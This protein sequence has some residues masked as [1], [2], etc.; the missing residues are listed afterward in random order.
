MTGF[1]DLYPQATLRWIADVN[2]FMVYTTGGMPIGAYD[3]MRMS[4]L[5]IGHGA[6]DGGIGYT[7]FDQQTGHEFSVAAGLTYNLR[8]NSTQYQ[9]GVDFHLDWAA[10]QFLS[11]H[12]QLGVAGYFYDQLTADT[13]VPP[14]LGNFET[15]V[16]GLGP[17]AGYCFP[18][19]KIQGYLNLKTYW[20]FAA[21]NRPSGWNTFLTFSITA[22]GPSVGPSSPLI[23]M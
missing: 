14:G 20:E 19:Q 17:Q 12:F 9:N 11:E 4:N 1:G 3:S 7:Y 8:N 10:S 22:I 2:N 21:E 16:V 6:I 15:R 18:I 5:G 23:T 13:G